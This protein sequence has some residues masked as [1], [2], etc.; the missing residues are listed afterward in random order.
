MI[1]QQRNFPD[2]IQN[3]TTDLT[4][5]AKESSSG[6]LAHHNHDFAECFC[7]QARDTGNAPLHYIPKRSDFMRKGGRKKVSCAAHRRQTSVNDK[8]FAEK[9]CSSKRMVSSANQVEIYHQNLSQ[10]YFNSTKSCGAQQE[11][12]SKSLRTILSEK[13]LCGDKSFDEIPSIAASKDIPDGKNHTNN[14]RSAPVTCRDSTSAFGL[15]KGEKSTT[16]YLLK[17]KNTMD[18]EHGR[19]YP[20]RKRVNINDDV[21]VGL[22]QV[23]KL[24]GTI[25]LNECFTQYL[26]G[27]FPDEEN[28]HAQRPK[29]S[30]PQS[31]EQ[32]FGIEDTTEMTHVVDESEKTQ[33]VYNKQVELGKDINKVFGKA[34]RPVQRKLS[35]DTG[36]STSFG[37][38]L[39]YDCLPKVV[40]VMSSKPDAIHLGF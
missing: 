32:A 18:T 17:R 13:Y 14:A 39:D 35:N 22:R 26:G 34:T 28:K 10:N 21:R 15:N 4:S 12:A 30:R 36:N 9:H 37:Y 24:K 1:Y 33:K 31:T 20:Q 3:V 11:T 7:K 19:E 6:F 5:R 16:P 25:D 23:Q 29:T 38:A 2:S 8:S 40:G 27:S